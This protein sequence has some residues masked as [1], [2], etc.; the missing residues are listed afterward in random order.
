MSDP[1]WYRDMG[2][3]QAKYD[4]FFPTASQSDAER[5]NAFVRLVGYASVAAFLIRFDPKYLIMGAAIVGVV[6]YAYEIYGKRARDEPFANIRPQNVQ[7][8]PR[9]CSRS[10]PEN[11][12]SNMTIGT[13]INEPTRAPACSYDDDGVAGDIRRN[14]NRGLF[15]NLEDVY[16]VENSQR[17]FYTMPVTTSAPDTIAFA[18][19]LYGSRGKTC[20]ELPEK[21]EPAF[22]T[23]N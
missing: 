16:E 5:L 21:C 14:F 7:K 9:K 4:E 12:F 23:R 22:A 2:I 20:K 3:L 11:P 17:Q 1:V 18:E 10:T 19:F 8:G 13:L 15:R 6:S